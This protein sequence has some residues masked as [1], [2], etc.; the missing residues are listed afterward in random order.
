MNFFLVFV[1]G[2]LSRKMIR[3]A[4]VSVRNNHSCRV[5]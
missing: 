5:W 1:F 3:H 4:N 2:M